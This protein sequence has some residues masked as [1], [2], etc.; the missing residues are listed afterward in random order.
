MDGATYLQ[1]SDLFEFLISADGRRIDYRPL[2][3]ATAESFSVYLLG[4]V[5]SFSLL[6]L[7]VEPLHGTVAVI[8]GHAVGFWGDCGYGK[9]TLGAALLARGCPILTDDVMVLEEKNAV[10]TVH[11][12]LP[13]LKL[14]PA[15][16]RRVLGTGLPGTP[17]NQRTS[18]LVLPLGPGQSC[19]RAVPLKALYVLSDPSGRTRA[20]PARPR[21]EPLSRRDACLEVIRAAFNLSVFERERLANQFAFATRLATSVPVHR[22]IYP[23]RMSALPEVCDAVFEDVRRLRRRD[24]T[25][26]S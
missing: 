3:H 9:S 21:I 26:H 11:P 25:A 16:A 23:R 5:L 4:Q 13:R 15:V 12:G 17:M 10:F 19:R 7:G 22:L 8:E 24:E 18:K 14:F 2:K 20:R 6:A 1:W